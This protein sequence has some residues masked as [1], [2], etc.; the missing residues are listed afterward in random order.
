MAKA[1][2]INTDGTLETG[3]NYWYNFE[4]DSSDEFS[5]NNGTDTDI[6]YSA[7]VIGNGAVFNGSSSKIT[8]AEDFAWTQI[9]FSFWV[10]FDTGSLSADRYFIA[11]TNASVSANSDIEL[12][13]YLGSSG[14]ILV[15]QFRDAT[16]QRGVSW[17]HG[18]GLVANTW[19]HFIGTLDETNDIGQL[20]V[21][22]DLK[23]QNTSLTQT[24][25]NVTPGLYF[26]NSWGSNFFDGQMDLVGVWTKILSAQERTDLYNAGAGNA[27]MEQPVTGPAN[28]KSY[29]TNLKANIKSVNTNPIANVKSLNTNT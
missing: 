27:Y 8:T 11:K 1:F 5:T 26:G 10:K 6:T 17:T 14:T 18:G 20:Y 28:L 13:F 7:A 29:N 2:N 12:E 19:Y 23:N 9:S 25:N 24:H 16:G 22:N 3:L 15:C 4:A 21:D